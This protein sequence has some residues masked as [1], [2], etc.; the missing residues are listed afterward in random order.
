MSFS[1]I[2]IKD[3][4]KVAEPNDLDALQN[5]NKFQEVIEHNISRLEL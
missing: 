1:R 4:Y 3:I 5:D 2:K